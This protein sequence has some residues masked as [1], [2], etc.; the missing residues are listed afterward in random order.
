MQQ[1][2]WY[3]QTY[4]ANENETR[5][6][7]KTQA[8]S[9]ANPCTKTW[10]IQR[11]TAEEFDMTI[12]QATKANK[13]EKAKMGILAERCPTVGRQLPKKIEEK[14]ILFYQEDE[15]SGILT[16]AWWKILS[17]LKGPMVNYSMYK[18]AFCYLI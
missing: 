14:V 8:H 12:C 7:S 17:L 2:Q 3:E 6:V 1:L 11:I 10:C 15:Y 5:S 18:N 13:L 16:R 9:V 4:G